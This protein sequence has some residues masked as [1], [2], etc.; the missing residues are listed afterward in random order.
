MQ[1]G[2]ILVENGEMKAKPG[3][4]RFLSTKINPATD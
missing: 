1:R 4:G 2:R 3:E